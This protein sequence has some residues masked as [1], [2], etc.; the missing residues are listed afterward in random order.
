ML[1]A[2]SLDSRGLDYSSATLFKL[3]SK[4]LLTHS[5]ISLMMSHL[6]RPA[7]PCIPNSHPISIPTSG[8]LDL[9]T[10]PPPV[11]LFPIASS[12]NIPN[13]V[14]DPSIFI[15]NIHPFKSTN[16]SDPD[17]DTLEE[18]GMKGNKETECSKLRN[19]R[20]FGC[21]HMRNTKKIS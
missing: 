15:F 11:L 5:N 19:P 4:P 18:W 14:R 3:A 20:I 8:P 10:L 16:T 7:W 17:P 1:V 9:V 12:E 6:L 2:A 21:F 13:Q